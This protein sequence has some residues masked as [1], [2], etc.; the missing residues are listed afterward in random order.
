MTEPVPRLVPR[1]AGEDPQLA[2][3]YAKT[4]GGAGEAPPHVF[5]TLGHHPDLLRRWLVFST[6]VLYKS[7]LPPR[8]RELLILRT[9]WNCRSRYEFSQH[10][11]IGL[12]CGI[13]AAQIEMV[14]HGPHAGWNAADRLLIEAADELHG[15]STL[16]DATWAA[17]TARY[18]TEQVLDLVAA[19]GNYHFVAMLVN[20]ARVALDPGVPDAFDEPAT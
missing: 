8:D 4:A 20:A 11:A 9:G 7:T 13:T 19:V 10:V 1:S 18:T 16:G 14:K 15:D 17:L 5:G 12:R 3:L 6:H 2:E